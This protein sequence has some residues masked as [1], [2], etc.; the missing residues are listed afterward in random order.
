MEHL[1]Y[2]A[3]AQGADPV[4]LALETA[5]ALDHAANDPMGMVVS[6]RR[7][8]EHHPLAAP[9]WWLCAQVLTSVDPAAASRDAARRLRDDATG[10]HLARMLVDEATVCTVGWSGHALGAFVRRGDVTVLVVDS[11]GDGHAMLHSLDRAQVGAELVAPEGV[12]AAAMAADV[13]LIP[14]H[15]CG[16]EEF[17]APGG[18]LAMAAVGYCSGT[19][20]WAVAGCGTRLP[21]RMWEAIVDRACPR[22][23]SWTNGVDRVPWSLVSHV[24][25]STGVA[26]RDQAD[27]DPECENAPELLRRS[28]L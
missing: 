19:D 5:D 12:G 28:A 23:E 13:V 9:L 16:R 3:R 27:L 18:S 24:V 4:E 2:V 17:L 6:A 11:L 8:V 15:A 26:V 21:G 1:R 25:G 10:E 22:N 14:V 7:M 20:V